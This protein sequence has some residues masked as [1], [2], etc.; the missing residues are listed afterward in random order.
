VEHVQDA[1]ISVPVIAVE[2][3]STPRDVYMKI[4]PPIPMQGIEADE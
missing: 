4:P 3:K 2:P 1:L